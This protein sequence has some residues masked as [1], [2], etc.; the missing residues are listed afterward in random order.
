MFESV[1]TDPGEDGLRRAARVFYVL[2]VLELL[3]C[4]VR[5][6][7]WLTSGALGR[8]GLAIAAVT[9]ALSYVTAQGIEQQRPWAKWLG[10]AL[11]VLLLI[12]VPI[13]T[14]IGIAVLVYINRANKAGLF[15]RPEPP[16][17]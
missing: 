15:A 5:V 4:G 2:T 12:N 14:V 13:G 9:M 1:R 17:L 7:V 10:I 6:V 11:G 16:A 3:S 8:L